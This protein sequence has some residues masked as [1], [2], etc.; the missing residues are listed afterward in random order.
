MTGRVRRPRKIHGAR[1]A[2]TVYGGFGALFLLAVLAT[3]L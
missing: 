3:H 1:L 2:V